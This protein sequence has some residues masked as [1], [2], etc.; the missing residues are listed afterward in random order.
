MCNIKKTEISVQGLPVMKLDCNIGDD[1]GVIKLTLSD[2][3]IPL[4]QEG[5]VYQFLDVRVRTFQNEKYL[6]PS[7]KEYS[8]A[9]K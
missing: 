7:F 4:V 2:R 5:H 9:E 6:S 3:N 8:T 1:T